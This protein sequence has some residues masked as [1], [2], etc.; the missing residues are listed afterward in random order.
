MV[1]FSTLL[2]TYTVSW[3]NEGA[4]LSFWLIVQT[5]L[6]ATVSFASLKWSASHWQSGSVSYKVYLVLVVS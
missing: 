3:T 5:F 1:E 4:L 2:L 6:S